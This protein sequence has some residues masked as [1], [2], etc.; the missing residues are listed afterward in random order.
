[1]G[2]LL[3]YLLALLPYSMQV[4]LGRLLGKLFYR[5][6]VRRRKITERNLELCFPHWTEAQRHGVTVQVMES[7]GIA[8]F[9]TGMAWFWPRWRFDR[10]FTMEGLEH[11]QSAKD[12]GVGVILMAFHFTHIDIGAKLL[13]LNF[14]IDGSYRPHNNA[15]YDYVQR[16]GRERHSAGGQAIS[17]DD[18]RSMVKSLRSG[19]AIWYAPDQDYGSNHSIFVPFF[20][21][22]AATVTATGKLARMGRAEVIAFTQT[23]KSDGSGYHLKIYPP[24]ENFPSDDDYADTQR[25]NQIVEA[26]ILEQPSQYLWV[27]RRFKTRPEGEPD[28]YAQAGIGKKKKKTRQN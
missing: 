10:L 4:W 22:P 17:R 14:S 12:K 2:F 28:L 27:H 25:I 26:R 18:L 19:R 15:V 1:L 16:T 21:V 20:G 7:L 6:A 11:L 24:L 13:S 9:E 5:L 3:W 23:R 8:F